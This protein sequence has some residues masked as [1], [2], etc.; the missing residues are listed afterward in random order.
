MPGNREND[1]KRN[2]V[3]SLHDLYGHTI[4]TYMAT[5]LL[6][7][8]W[9]LLLWFTLPWSS[10]LYAQFALF[11]PGSRKSIC[12]QIHQFYTYYPKI[13]SPWDWEGGGM[14]FTISRLLTLFDATYRTKFGKGWP[15]S[16]W[17]GD[18]NAWRWKWR[19]PT[20]SNR[21]PEWLGWPKNCLIWFNFQTK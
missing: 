7:E 21:L 2:N 12:E 17:K 14:K 6:W 1:F 3:F 5:S 18:V 19:T 13:I 16:S 8:S 4:A 15:S 20:N 10:L 9:N 11:L